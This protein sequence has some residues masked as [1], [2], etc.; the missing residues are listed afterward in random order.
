MKTH[1]L[2]FPNFNGCNENEQPPTMIYKGQE[3]LLLRRL[4]V[5][6]VADLTL[7]EVRALIAENTPDEEF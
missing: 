1:S 2:V 3:L 5:G 4:V 6:S 7:P